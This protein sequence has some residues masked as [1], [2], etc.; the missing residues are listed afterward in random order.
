[1]NTSYPGDRTRS[2]S[3]H[4]DY[5]LGKKRVSHRYLEILKGMLNPSMNVM[6]LGC[7]GGRLSF[8]IGEEAGK[9]VGVDLS[10]DLV[11]GARA[12]ADQ[13][14]DS[15]LKFIVGDLEEEKTWALAREEIGG[16]PFDILIS[17]AMMRKDTCDISTI[18]KHSLNNLSGGGRIC[19]RIQ[20]ANDL[21]ELGVP[22]P[23]YSVREVERISKISGFENLS[24]ER[25]VFHQRFSSSDFVFK[26]LERTD[27]MEYYGNAGNMDSIKG[28]LERI[29]GKRG[30]TLQRHYMILTA[31][32]Q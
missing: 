4:R 18:L 5:W 20:D 16:T 22:S 21:R 28:R 9:V 27:L 12:K 14:K 7:G 29:E 32:R 1:M 3:K 31:G 19:Y 26:F 23:C 30:L 13:L 25:E 11:V 2:Y 15:D 17:N 24:I 8:L 10:E 6:D